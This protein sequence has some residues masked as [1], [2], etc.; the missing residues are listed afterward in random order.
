[1]NERDHPRLPARISSNSRSVECVRSR[2]VPKRHTPPGRTADESTPPQRRSSPKPGPEGPAQELSAV[3]IQKRMDTIAAL[4]VNFL[5]FLI[6]VI[7]GVM[8]L[9]GFGLD[10]G[11]AI[12]GLGVVGIAV[13]F[14]AQHR[15]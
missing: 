1:M 8:L 13:G 5:R 10:V 7:A 4:A 9:G 11:P 6:V 2:M 3:E 12:A 15:G 14:G